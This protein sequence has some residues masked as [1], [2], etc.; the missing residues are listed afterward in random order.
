MSPSNP[1]SSS[2]YFRRIRSATRSAAR[3][4]P[5]R[6]EEWER[7]TLR[8]L[9]D[10]DTNRALAMYNDHG[11]ITIGNVADGTK[12]LARRRLVGVRDFKVRTRRR[13]PAHT[14]APRTLPI[15]WSRWHTAS[16][17]TEPN[18]SP[19]TR[20][21]RSRSPH[22]RPA[23]WRASR[24]ASR[25]EIPAPHPGTVSASEER[26]KARVVKIGSRT[27]RRD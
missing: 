1:V 17:S 23:S 12:R 11:R 25:R 14:P 18:T 8:D 13:S 7:A 27:W 3:S 19:S 26:F 10:G 24:S 22:A 16:N 20:W 21:P 9:R 15:Q 4:R 5:H 2:V 6:G